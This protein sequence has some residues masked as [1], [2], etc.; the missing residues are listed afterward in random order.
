MNIKLLKTFFVCSRG[1]KVYN[2]TTNNHPCTFSD[3]FRLYSSGVPDYESVLVP[4]RYKLMTMDN[5]T[6][7]SIEEKYIPTNKIYFYDSINYFLF[8]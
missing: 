2:Y 5:V 3:A 6:P 8:D 4:Y 1:L 7:G